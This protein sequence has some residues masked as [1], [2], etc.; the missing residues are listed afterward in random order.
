MESDGSHAWGAHI[1]E[2]TNDSTTSLGYYLGRDQVCNLVKA[3]LIL[4]PPPLATAW[5]RLSVHPCRGRVY[6]CLTLSPF[7]SKTAHPDQRPAKLR[8]RSIASNLA[9]IMVELRD[10][11]LPL[12][13]KHHLARSLAEP[14]PYPSPYIYLCQVSIS[15]TLWKAEVE[16]LDTGDHITTI[17]FITD[18]IRWI[19]RLG[20]MYT[21]RRQPFDHLPRLLLRLRPSVPF[22]CTLPSRH[23]GVRLGT[24]K[25]SGAQLEVRHSSMWHLSS[26]GHSLTSMLAPFVLPHP[27][28]CALDHFPQPHFFDF[29][30][31]TDVVYICNSIPSLIFTMETLVF[32]MESDGNSAFVLTEIRRKK[33]EEKRETCTEGSSINQG[34]KRRKP[35]WQG[36]KDVVALLK[37]QLSIM[38]TM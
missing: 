35:R 31:A 7:S 17:T 20:G 33:S 9:Q 1:L 37:M 3:E 12:L 10:I 6:P 15:P 4:G 38:C 24:V 2:D 30:V 29:I 36:W 25:S 28:Q 14:R 22:V 16:A 8:P 34:E 11:S 5:L 27:S 23:V 32:D 26:R 13:T 19:P 18:G 21:G